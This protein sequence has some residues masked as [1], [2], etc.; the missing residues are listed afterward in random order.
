MKIITVNLRGA[1]KLLSVGTKLLALVIIFS[2]CIY[3]S[4]LIFQNSDYHVEALNEIT[5]KSTVIIDAG[6]GGEDCGAIGASGIYEKDLNLEIA[7][8]LG[9]LFTDAG[10]AVIYT[11]TED[12]LLYTAE[13]DIHGI[14]KFSDLKNRC[15]IG[16]EYEDSI[17][18]SIHMNSYTNPKYSGLHT[19]YSENSDSSYNLAAAIQSS[20]KDTL[21]PENNRVI[22]P[23]KN[24]YLLEN[25]ENTAVLIECGFLSNPDECQK[26][27]EKEY[28]K[29]LSFAIFCGIINYIDSQS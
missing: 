28:Q 24:M 19:Y 11:R 8:I 21:Q 20:V 29:Q 5:S 4:G 18:V 12:K 15:K 17:F 10:Y 9:A 1:V 2:L 13:E 6:H 26:L 7:N 25:L 23:G 14:R 3:S 27:S 22:K 16:A